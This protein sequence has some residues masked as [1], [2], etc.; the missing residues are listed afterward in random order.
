MNYKTKFLI[1]SIEPVPY[2]YADSHSSG[3]KFPSLKVSELQRVKRKCFIFFAVQ[4]GNGLGNKNSNRKIRVYI[5]KNY[6]V[7]RN[8]LVWKLNDSIVDIVFQRVVVTFI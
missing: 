2:R 6:L 4:D 5:T 8:I 1:E 3:E 7:W